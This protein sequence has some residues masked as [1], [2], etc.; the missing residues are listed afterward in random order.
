MPPQLSFAD[1]AELTGINASTALDA[2]GCVDNVGILDCAADSACGALSCA[3]STTLTFISIDNV[4]KKALADAC[5]AL[6]INNV[7]NVFFAEELES[8]KNGVGSSL[9]ETAE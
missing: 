4:V 1:S 9:T 3:E 7:C 5:G 8:C 6:L 2:L